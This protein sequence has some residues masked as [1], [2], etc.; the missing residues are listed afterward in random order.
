MGIFYAKMFS[1]KE[2]KLAFIKFS[3]EQRYTLN[4]VA[5]ISDVHRDTIKDWQNN[6]L[7]FG[8]EGFERINQQKTFSKEIEVAAVQDY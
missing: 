4:E 7:Y 6:Y 8:E 2:E 3:H 1:P 5:K